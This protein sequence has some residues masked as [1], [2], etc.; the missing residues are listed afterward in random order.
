MLETINLPKIKLNKFSHSLNMFTGLFPLLSN[1]AMTVR[2][3]L[4]MIYETHFVP[5]GQRLRPGLNGFLSGSRSDPLAYMR[6]HVYSE[7]NN[8]PT[9]CVC[10]LVC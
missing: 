2:S 3:M 7:C 5:L 6:I 1:A 4:L 10:A 9:H 8:T